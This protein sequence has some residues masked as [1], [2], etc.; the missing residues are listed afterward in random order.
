MRCRSRT[1]GADR[2][3]QGVDGRQV[4]PLSG[5]LE[6]NAARLLQGGARQLGQSRSAGCCTCV[7]ALHAR[8]CAA[9]ATVCSCRYLAADGRHHRGTPWS[10]PLQQ[11]LDLAGEGVASVAAGAHCCA[12]LS[13]SGQLY[14]W[15]CLLDQVR[16]VSA[17]LAEQ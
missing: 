14:L 11:H 4:G 10:E 17:A 3:A 9:G 16:V 2:R 6:D 13:G 7:L 1:R 12:A 15:G 5:G 8:A